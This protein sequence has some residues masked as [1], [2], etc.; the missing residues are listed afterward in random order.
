MLSAELSGIDLAFVVVFV[1]YGLALF[2]LCEA[3]L[4]SSHESRP[5]RFAGSLKHLAAF[6]LLGALASWLDA[7]FV[8]TGG[9]APSDAD[10]LRVVKTVLLALAGASLLRFGSSLLAHSRR[11]HRWMLAIPWVMLGAWLVTLVVSFV[12]PVP[13]ASS[14]GT[15]CAECHQAQF[16]ALVSTTGNW[17]TTADIWAHYLLYCP[18]AILTAGAFVAQRKRFLRRG[19][20]GIGRNS[21]LAAVGFAITA[22]SAGL[23]V[24]PATFFPASLLNYATFHSALRIPTQV[25]TTLATVLIAYSVVMTLRV[26]EIERAR[27]LA[28]ARE[29]R[30]AAQHEILE[31]QNRAQ[32]RMIDWNRQ[33]EERVSERTRELEEAHARL[34]DVAVL[35]ERDRI[36]RELHDSLAQ[37]LGYL[38]LRASV[39]QELLESRRVD[40]AAEEV[41][42]IAEVVDDAY[43][44]VREAILGLR[45]KTDRQGLV[46]AL[47]EYLRKYG[48]QTGIQ[49]Q[50]RVQSDV[51]LALAPS[52]ETQLIRVVQEA[53]ANV[54]KHARA[55]RAVVRLWVERGHTCISVEDDGCG[56][57]P[58]QKAAGGHYGLATMRERVQGVDGTLEVKSAPGSGTSVV[59]CLPMLSK[60]PRDS[61]GANAVGLALSSHNDQGTASSPTHRTPR[62][63]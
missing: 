51:D 6:G 44:D 34:K 28:R 24:P 56:F 45:T 31:A 48:L 11:Q 55:E 17:L 41:R 54:R 49:T 27:Q 2:A 21:L 14:S 43:A 46:P 59:V 37:A 25:V 58:S 8:L 60:P 7:A 40:E 50:L 33:L 22:V 4:L 53:L 42:T 10:P 52:V 61:T 57:D 15:S 26:F 63:N 35:E 23:V 5:T 30:F 47:A 19:M 16:S 12:G 9:A 29:A 39:L 3:A 36:A 20:P 32:A 62:T 38:G 13:G 18:G 1:V